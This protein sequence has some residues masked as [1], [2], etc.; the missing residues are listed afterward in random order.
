MKKP[1]VADIL[2][3]KG[4]RVLTEVL[5]TD[6]D[7]AR[8]CETAGIDMLITAKGYTK[9]VRSGAW[10]TFLTAGLP[11]GQYNA[12]DA[13][14]IRAAFETIGEGADAI[15]ACMSM[16]RIRGMS[17]EGIPVIGHCGLVP[18]LLTWIGGYRAVGKTAD[19]ALKVYRDTLALQEAGAFAVEMEVVPDRVAAEITKRVDIF[20]ISMGSGPGC[21]GHYLF[22]CDIL[23][24][25]Q[26]HYPRHSKTYRSFHA[27]MQRLHE[28]AVAAMGEFKADVES[29]AYPAKKHMVPIKDRE[30]DKFMEQVDKVGG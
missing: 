28:E 19:E 5:V 9:T 29:G 7:T 4:R 13:E 17:R 8:A 30:F 6:T 16:E 1:T 24:T 12:S 20:V 26:G 10:N 23:G 14:A 3:C 22:A 11:Y 2:A 15:Y 21:D 27:E 25:H 18:E